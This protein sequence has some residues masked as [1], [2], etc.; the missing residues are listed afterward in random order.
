MD[1]N[2][3]DRIAFVR[4]CSGRFKR[5]MRLF[6]PR[7]KKSINVSSPIFFF[8]QQRATVDDALPGDIIGVPNH[9]ALRVGDTL[10][11]GEALRFTGIPNFA[12]EVLRRVVLEDAMKAKQLNKAL[13]DLAEEGVVQIF[14]PRDGGWP[15]L[16]AVG[17][18]QF[19][20]LSSRLA[21]EYGVSVRLEGA[22]Y[23]TARWIVSEK[24]DMLQRFLDSHRSSVADDGAGDPV[25]LARNSWVLSNA[26]EEWPDVKFVAVK[27]RS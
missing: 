1:P 4:L 5:G 19:D 9:G 22:P 17:V 25:F 21:A 23:E 3:R 20:V 6:N 24:P 14:R 11:E 12:P 16:G 2:H 15:V 10:T 27:E 18:L 13:N 8:A 7:E 26:V